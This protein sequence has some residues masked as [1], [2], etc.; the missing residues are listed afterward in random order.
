[1]GGGR[2]EHYVI[3]MHQTQ[4]TRFSEHVVSRT[5]LAHVASRWSPAVLRQLQG[6]ERRY[7]QL[8]SAIDGVSEKMLGQTLRELERN[9]LVLRTSY[10][11][12]P[13]HVVYAL[14]GLGH[15]CADRVTALVGWLDENV[16]EVGRARDSYNT[17]R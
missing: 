2:F 14:T 10:P 9:G 1:V 15:A 3:C 13:P 11:V 6:G 16:G 8:R 4:N 17:K 12:V 5:V 7:S